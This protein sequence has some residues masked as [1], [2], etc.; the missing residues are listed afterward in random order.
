MNG[1][2]RKN[3]LFKYLHVH[4]GNSLGDVIVCTGIIH[5]LAKSTETLILD[6]NPFYKESL[7]CLFSDF[8]NILPLTKTEYAIFKQDKGPIEEIVAPSASSMPIVFPNGEKGSAPFAWE[9]QHYENF[10]LPFSTRYTQFHMPRHIPNA[11]AL[12]ETLMEGE[13]NYIVTNRFMGVELNYANYFIDRW[14]PHKYK[15]I[16]ITPHMT[17]NVFDFVELFRHAKQIHVVPTS[18][19]QLVDS[20]VNDI[21][22]E[23]FFHNIRANFWSPVNCQFNEYRWKIINYLDKI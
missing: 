4:V 12:Y 17:T 11:H 10:D 13:E 6:T 16:D 15:V 23:L 18:I 7:M 8:P 3:Y 22:G 21:S 19:H 2:R 9:R 5:H 20:M 14:N 1:I